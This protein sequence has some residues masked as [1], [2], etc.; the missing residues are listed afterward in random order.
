MSH[1]LSLC[2]VQKFVTFRD[3]E[4]NAICI[5]RWVWIKLFRCFPSLPTLHIFPLS[6]PETTQEGKERDGMFMTKETMSGGSGES[7]VEGRKLLSWVGGNLRSF[8]P[9]L[10]LMYI[11]MACWLPLLWV[12]TT[13]YWSVICV[14]LFQ[15]LSPFL[16]S[17]LFN[18]GF[19]CLFFPFVFFFNCLCAVL[20]CPVNI[21]P[22]DTMVIEAQ[23][24]GKFGSYSALFYFSDRPLRQ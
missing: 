3:W 9:W 20:R 8:F 17:F 13:L 15:P 11:N 22:R 24:K 2:L 16:L 1:F 23:K 10:N 12:A 5:G 19:L 7:H 18:M 21:Y 6:V 4:G 14:V